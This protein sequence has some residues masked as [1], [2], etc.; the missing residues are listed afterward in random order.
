MLRWRTSLAAASLGGIL[1]AGVAVGPA[2]ARPV[3][4]KPGQ[5]GTVV[6]ALSAMPATLD[7][8][9]TRDQYSVD[10]QAL[11]YDALYT[12]TPSLGFASDLASRWTVS[13]R[14]TTYLYQLTTRARWSNGRPVT[15]AD[16]VQ[17]L[18]RYASGADRSPLRSVFAD[19]GSVRALT[20]SLVQ[21]RLR[22]PWAGWPDVLAGLPILPA[23]G[24]AA[25]SVKAAAD[26][27][28]LVTDGPFRLSRW[29]P[30]AGEAVFVAN[31]QYFR[32][33]PRVSRIVLRVMADPA[34]VVSALRRGL[35]QVAFLPPALWPRL[36]K[37]A[38]VRVTP[39][40]TLG[41]DVIA[42]NTRDPVLADARVRRALAMAVDRQEVRRTVFAGLG[43][44]P[45]GP[46]PPVLATALGVVVAPL[47]YDPAAARALLAAAGWQRSA[48]GV[49]ARRGVRLVIRLAY[50]IDAPRLGRALVVVAQAWRRVG[51]GVTLEAMPFASLAADVADGRFAAAAL[52]M[53]EPTAAALGELV[54]P[55]P[56]AGQNVARLNDS[57]VVRIL[58]AAAAAPSPARAA[59]LY[60]AALRDLAASEPYL[61]LVSGEGLVATSATLVGFVPNP[62]GPDLYQ[63]QQWL[64]R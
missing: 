29:D 60:D 45:E 44:V 3:D 48:G 64:V 37:L 33:P 32:G 9:V 38:D 16:V 1:A 46:V 43:Q 34:D 24:T 13:A 47:P 26:P 62:A 36:H 25:L 51:V 59:R 53:S 42:F 55:P 31:A 40:A 30:Y 28:A 15:A 49:R 50:P 57:A 54:G 35:V 21:V 8:L 17:S 18:D 23:D 56:P 27:A 6:V 61:P 22:R 7:P 19:V 20:P 41:L 2:L 4:L 39:V 14:A 63:P 11:L 12:R 10:A 58:A 5:P 52:G